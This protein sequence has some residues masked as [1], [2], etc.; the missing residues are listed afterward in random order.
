MNS[1]IEKAK[2]LFGKGSFTCVLCRGE[3]VI[4]SSE[5]GLR[6]LLKLIASGTDLSGFSAADKIVGRAA[7][8]LYLILGVRAVYAPVM[9]HKAAVLLSENSV[10]VSYDE[11]PED[12]L[13]RLANGICPMEEAVKDCAEPNE[14]LS[15]IKNRIAEMSAQKQS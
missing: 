10:N 11:Y 9:S 6:P 2:E 7:A 13:N 8:Y 5:K 15:A 14:A 4:T 12:I 3:E 1:D